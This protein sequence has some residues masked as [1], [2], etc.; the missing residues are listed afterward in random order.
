MQRDPSDEAHILA[1]SCCKHYGEDDAAAA[2][3]AAPG[4][5]PAARTCTDVSPAVANSVEDSTVDGMEWNRF[6][7]DAQLTAQDLVDR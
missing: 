5:A 3:G 1:S 6:E 7:V 2:P 4:R